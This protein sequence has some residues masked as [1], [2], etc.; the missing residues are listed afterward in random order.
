VVH[1]EDAS[2]FAVWQSRIETYGLAEL[3]VLANTT[4]VLITKRFQKLNGE[5]VFEPRWGRG[6][7]DGE[8]MR[9]G[10]I[11]LPGVP[12]VR[13]WQ[14]P[15]TWGE[16]L[17]VLEDFNHAH[18]EEFLRTLHR[19]RDGRPHLFL[20]GF[21]LPA[22][23]GG[24]AVEMHWRAIAIPALSFGVIH[25]RGFRDRDDHAQHWRND[26]R[27]L[28]RDDVMLDWQKSDN[29]SADALA[30]RGRLAEEVRKQRTA[31]LGCGTLGSAVGELVTRTGTHR[32]VL[33]DGELFE[34]GNLCRHILLLPD[35]KTPKAASLGKRLVQVNPHVDA[36]VLNSEFPPKE[37]SE[38]AELQ[39]VDLLIDCT[40]EDTVIRH[41][42]V[43]PWGK[44]INFVSIW[45]GLRA[46]RLFCFTARGTAY[47]VEAFNRL[48][49]P[50]LVQERA[51]GGIEDFPRE[52]VGCWH[53]VFPARLDDVWLLAASAVKHI[54]HELTSG[55]KEPKLV[56]FEQETDSAGFSGVRRLAGEVVNGRSRLSIA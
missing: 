32:V 55:I 9:A 29:W 12:I 33:S 38:R 51:E 2:S 35:I 7:A 49:Q 6:I 45:L 47:P 8:S 43:F 18:T 5:T 44:E 22:T 19:L 39:A 25:R 42:G 28:L 31:I 50:W 15:R 34:A 23:I 1:A 16:L 54:E 17:K 40:A 13:P 41:M 20:L 14:A 48:V 10:W 4:G 37:E 21:P 46:R 27:N 3:T 36:V 24:A 56:V 53:P 52:G 26:R 11:R 30:T